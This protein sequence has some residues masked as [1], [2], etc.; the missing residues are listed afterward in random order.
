MLSDYAVEGEKDTKTTREVGRKAP[1]KWK[2]RGKSA[3]VLGGGAI[4]GKKRICCLG[5]AK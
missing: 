4:G 1:S 5:E 3:V 2:A